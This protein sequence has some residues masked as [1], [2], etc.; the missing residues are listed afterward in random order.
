MADDQDNTPR[1][2][3]NGA[4]R[5]G[6]RGEACGGRGGEWAAETVKRAPQQPA[7]PQCAT[8]WAPL[9]RKRG[10]KEHRPQ[11]PTGSGD[12]TQ[13]AKG[14]TGDCPGP[15]KETTTR[16][17]VT[18]GGLTCQTGD[19]PPPHT[20]TQWTLRN[21]QIGRQNTLLALVDR[22]TESSPPHSTPFVVNGEWDCTPSLVCKQ[23]AQSETG[24]SKNAPKARKKK[25]ENTPFPL[26]GP[27]LL[28]HG[29][30]GPEL[31]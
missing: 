5:T 6:Q 30:S 16:R 27:P 15:H 20:P 7:H 12:P 26:S 3:S 9:T 13:H 19:P 24:N 2:W 1:G 14:R 8:H 28:R 29:G 31:N 21:N 4:S 10:R 17:N 22:G 18:Q 25:P 11:R 23:H